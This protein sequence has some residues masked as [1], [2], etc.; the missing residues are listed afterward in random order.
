MLKME[1]IE[2]FAS[3]AETGS[4]TGAARR[5][6]ISKSVISERLAEL[7]RTLG[8]TL[9]HRTTRKLALTDDG[10]AFYQRAKAILLDVG[11]AA[12]EL[13]ERRGTLAGPLRISAPVS[14][15]NLHLGPALF[16]FLAKNP[17]IEMTLELDDNFVDM[18]TAGYDAVVRHG[19][20]DDKR[21][22]VKRLA[23]SRRL[24]VAS[25]DYLKRYGKP[26]SL[27]ALERH[28]G[29]IYSIRGGGDWRFRVGKKF[30]TIHPSAALRVNN[31][32]IMRDAAV[33][34]LGIALLPTFILQGPLKSRTLRDLNV[35]AEPEG[36]SIYIA[37]PQHLRSSKKIRALTAWLQ[38]AFGDPAYWDRLNMSA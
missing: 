5:L 28:R 14:F 32:M 17:R 34:G 26:T 13:A 36:A 23:A 3:I 22:I 35:G 7:E 6:A 9:I 11:N 21:I 29:I 31:G 27:K 30:I 4:L 18:L 2:A 12:S 33:A 8:S 37:Y 20:V 19:P 10:A 24:L 15:G 16:E 1:S 38:Q 25:P